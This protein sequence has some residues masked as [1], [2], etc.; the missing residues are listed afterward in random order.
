MTEQTLKFLGEMI[1]YGGGGAVVAYLTFQFLG[2][3]WIENK[4]TQRLDY[5][6]HQQ[7]LELQR[8]RVEIDALLSGAIK[9][10]E[11][12]FQVLPKAWQKLDEAYGL[13]SSLVHPMQEYPDV[14]RMSE[15]QLEEFLA[16]TIF[17]ESQKHEIQSS[18]N[19]LETY[20]DIVF[21]HRYRKVKSAFSE[22]QSFVARNGIFF[23]PELKEQF[24]RIS[25][26]LWS[27]LVSKEVGHEASDHKMQREGWQKIKDDA[28]PLYKK[29]EGAIQARL[30]SH[31]RKL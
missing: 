30:Q 2:K 27:A 29:I 17:T 12:E 16:S 23:T 19:K 14:D 25:E 21:W 5:L 24:T 11:R 7:A 6:K 18:R 8:L 28:E 1:A 9:L 13:I 26:M 4:F 3:S 20:K 22:L 10:Q 31:G 15:A